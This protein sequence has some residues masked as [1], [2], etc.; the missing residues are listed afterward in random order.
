MSFVPKAS[1][2]SKAVN[3]A[4]H[5]VALHLPHSLPSRMQRNPLN[6]P[7]LVDTCIT[8]LRESRTDVRSC[9]LVCRGWV[10]S[11]QAC[12]F[13][14]AVL[15]RSWWGSMDD[16][17]RLWCQLLAVL[18]S[19]PHLIRHIRYLDLNLKALSYD[20]LMEQIARVSFSRLARVT[21]RSWSMR[22]APALT[23][24]L[25]LT[26]LRHKS[27]KTLSPVF[28]EGVPPLA[29]RALEVHD[30]TGFISAWLKHDHCPFQ[31]S[32]L[33]VLAV[34]SYPGI[35]QWSKLRPALPHLEAL[36]FWV[37]PHDGPV[38]LSVFPN[39]AFLALW[40]GKTEGPQAVSTLLTI[41]PS[42]CLRN[43]AL[44]A[45]LDTGSCAGM[46]SALSRILLHPGCVVEL[47]PS[48]RRNNYVRYFPQLSSR[49]M[50]HQESWDLEWFQRHHWMVM[51]QIASP[52]ANV[53]ETGFTRVSKI[54]RRPETHT[55]EKVYR[56]FAYLADIP[57]DGRARD[58]PARRSAVPP[59][60]L[61][62]TMPA[63]LAWELANTFH[64]CTDTTRRMTYTHRG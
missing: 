18:A 47:Q 8:H 43:V 14:V 31:F 9:A 53:K 11:A 20:G 42:N 26:T 59:L 34:H 35:L 21:V 39:L 24:L 64:R 22:A 58:A 38:D 1:V 2:S 56:M 23:P 49:A 41:S 51:Y 5:V 61:I 63:V 29:L 57:T 10:Y 28:R 27:K 15:W 37:R 13:E 60:I 7:E 45:S 48:P 52:S 50:V 12:I 17:R 25:A 3:T 4:H 19:S 55:F 62:L 32:G 33:R 44:C 46:D 16:Y 40:I 6:V 36:Q 30:M 54:E